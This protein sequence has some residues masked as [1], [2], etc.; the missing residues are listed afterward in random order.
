MESEPCRANQSTV[1][2]IMP[3]WPNTVLFLGENAQYGYLLGTGKLTDGVCFLQINGHSKIISKRIMQL[4][5]FKI[6]TDRR[7]FCNLPQVYTHNAQLAASRLQPLLLS[8]QS[9][10]SPTSN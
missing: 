10:N 8:I 5:Q 2:A 7:F 9:P 6:P 3:I 1:F 4:Q